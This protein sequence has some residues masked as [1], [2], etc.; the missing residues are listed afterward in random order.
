MKPFMK[1]CYKCK[2]NVKV[3]KCIKENIELNCMK[4]S[5]CGEEYFTS[6]ELLKF[7]ILGG[8]K[9]LVRKFG[10]LHGGTIETISGGPEL[11]A[12]I[13]AVERLLRARWGES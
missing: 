8:K 11:G 2:A 9:S 12:A 1:T 13:D 10:E 5:N 7:D 3:A 6:S 4:C